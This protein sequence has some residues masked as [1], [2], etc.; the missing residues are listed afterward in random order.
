MPV[1][2][3]ESLCQLTALQRLRLTAC[4]GQPSDASRFSMLER[5]TSLR[6]D[7]SAHAFWTKFEG[8]T[9]LQSLHLQ[10]APCLSF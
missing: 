6:L 9:G 1:V 8:C 2:P 3:A 4:K 5:L 10:G 7:E